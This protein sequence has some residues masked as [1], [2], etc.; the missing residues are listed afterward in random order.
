MVIR[1]S[2]T[3]IVSVQQNGSNYLKAHN[4]R[5]NRS[6]RIT[7]YGC[8]RFTFSL[9]LWPSP[10]LFSFFLHLIHVHYDSEL[11]LPASLLL[12]LM[13][14]CSLPNLVR[15]YPLFFF[16][17]VRCRD[18]AAFHSF[19]L[20]YFSISSF[21]PSSGGDDGGML[22]TSLLSVCTPPTPTFIRYTTLYTCAN[23]GG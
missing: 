13:I 3:V 15:C 7:L 2:Y 20:C 1:L 16:P 14:F 12:C 9:S 6:Q 10:S 18:T 17:D 11:S 4:D 23:R 19:V 22:T 8:G 21:F 5:W